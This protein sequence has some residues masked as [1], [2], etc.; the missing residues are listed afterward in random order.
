[1]L[2]NRT[3]NYTMKKILSTLAVAALTALG[4]HAQSLTL[5]AE[6]GN[7]AIDQANCWGFGAQGYTNT[8]GQVISGNWSVRSNQLTSMLPSASWV[9]SPFIKFRPGNITFQTRLD[10]NPGTTRSLKV[11]RIPVNPANNT[12]R[13]GAL[14]EIYSYNFTSA[15]TTALI[16]HTVNVPASWNGQ[17]YKIQFSWLGTGGTGRL[18]SDNFDIP[19]EYW[20]LPAN[21]CWP[22]EIIQDRDGDG[23]PDAEDEYPD[24]DKRA[25]NCY[26]PAKNVFGTLMFEDLWPSRGDYDFN[27]VVADYNI[28]H[29]ANAQNKVVESKITVALRAAGGS[30]KNGL[31]FQFKGINANKVVSVAGNK[32]TGSVHSFASNG[33]ESGVTGGASIVVFDNAYRV[34]QIPPGGT[35][36]NTT[37]GIAKSP[38]DTMRVTVS[39]RNANGTASAGGDV[40]YANI[41]NALFNPFITVNQQRGVEVHLLDGTPTNLANPS[42]LGTKDDKS[43]ASQGRFY[44]TANNLPF[45]LNLPESVPYMN[46][47]AEITTGYLRLID[48]AVSG[49]T[50]FTNWYKNQAGNR[51]ENNL[52]R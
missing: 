27:D 52:Y 24:D 13:E 48:W 35:G 11:Y 46:E 18:L 9:K 42:L 40:T 4:A 21:N 49:G 32:I 28:K 43:N 51:N 31:V 30:Y 17:V 25:F 26:Y 39:Y 14:E 1:M 15:T 3:S 2:N 22:K 41:D 38:V 12:S 5:D 37:P 45:A 8:S 36:I 33:T 29:V 6:S 19:G 34:L 47:R 7:R 44:R 20:A 23:V 50:Q 10:G 16:S